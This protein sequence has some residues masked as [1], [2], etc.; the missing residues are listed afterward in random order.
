MLASS[1]RSALSIS[2]RLVS[3]SGAHSTEGAVATPCLSRRPFSVA[4][5]VQAQERRRVDSQ[6]A[7]SSR[8]GPYRTKGSRPPSRSWQLPQTSLTYLSDGTVDPASQLAAYNVELDR[9]ASRGMSVQVLRLLSDMKRVGVRP[10][11]RT[12]NMLLSVLA[13]TAMYNE[14]LAVM[15]DMKAMGVR[16]DVQTYNHVINAARFHDVAWTYDH[17][18]ALE[19]DDLYPN[20]TTY[21]LVIRKCC[22][23]AK[24][25]MVLRL[26]VEMEEKGLSPKLETA[27][28]IIALA[29]KLGQPRLAIDLAENFEASSVR[30]LEN[31]VWVDCLTAS[32]ALLFTAFTRCGKESS[33]TSKSRRTRASASK[34][35]IPRH[36]TACPISPWTSCRR[37]N[38]SA[39]SCKSTTSP[40]SSRPTRAQAES[41]RPSPSSRSCARRTSSRAAGAAHPIFI[42]IQDSP[43][44]V[45]AAWDVLE[46]MHKK[47]EPV[48]ITAI[49]AIVQASVAQG[50]LQRAVGTYQA[51]A[52]FDVAPDVD[53]Y[54]ALLSGCI[55]ARHRELGDRLLTEMREAG[56][57]PD[58]HT[59]ERLVVLCLTSPTYEDAFFYLEEMKA[60]HHVP[61][62][63]VYEA[64]VRRCVSEGDTRYK[65]ALEEMRE[66]GYHV[67]P[68]L[69]RFIESGGKAGAGPQSTATAS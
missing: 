9:L 10:D 34:R 5:V 32:T 63:G 36:G 59:Y 65:L 13:D 19:K 33:T 50:D 23:D 52:E 12:Y 48:D 17:M 58:L 61:P 37:S 8:R 53:T 35:S 47:A 18:Q 7:N 40:P 38:P 45:D 29:A 64:I 4:T 44:A 24:L 1:S 42:A 21:A 67:S 14:T 62:Y 26:L 20:A 3:R 55:A 30:R 69:A 56:V 22:L 60:E 27:Q 15:E 41:K 49:N 31:H 57:K 39:R 51:S 11:L 6:S 28:A 43:A 25:E 2:R 16:P 46:E 68:H 54:N 66:V